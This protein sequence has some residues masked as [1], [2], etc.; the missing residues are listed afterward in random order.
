MRQ[1]GHIGVSLI[2][3]SPL[4]GILFFLEWF[5][6]G[7]VSTFVLL[8]LASFPDIDIK[9]KNNFIGRRLGIKHRGFT[10]TLKFAFLMSV[11]IALFISP[12]VPFPTP[13]I[14]FMVLGLFGF[15]GIAFHIAGDIITPTGVNFYPSRLDKNYTLNLFKFNNLIANFTYPLLGFALLFTF[16]ALG[17]TGNPQVLMSI[18]IGYG[19]ILPSVTYLSM[20]VSWEY[21][22]GTLKF[23]KLM[24]PK[25][26]FSKLI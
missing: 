19:L 10:H 1:E 14:S 17:I 24:N 23:A 18:L 11:F 12:F 6:L 20:K 4:I 22:R 25:Y 9:L 7:I 26:W 21:N 8:S 16:I 15:L 2:L 5:M 3:G 13:G